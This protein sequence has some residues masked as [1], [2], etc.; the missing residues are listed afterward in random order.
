MAAVVRVIVCWQM[1][2]EKVAVLGFRV[3]VELVKVISC[4]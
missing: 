1:P 4:W 2:F 3:E